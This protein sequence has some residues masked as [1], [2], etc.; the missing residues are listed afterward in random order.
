MSATRRALFAAAWTTL[1]LA[2]CAPPPTPG[3]LTSFAARYQLERARRSARLAAAEA[4]LIVRVEGRGTG[5]LPGL[6]VSARLAAP[7][8]CRLR[9]TWMLGTAFDLLAERDS[10]RAWLPT[11]HALIEIGGL[12]DSLRRPQ[13]VAL[14]LTAL[15][16]SW[17][18]PAAAWAAASAESAVVRLAWRDGADS[19]SLELDDATRPQRM[20]IQR[21]G[22]VV[23]VRYSG[24]RPVGGLQWP[25]RIEIADEAEWFRLRTELQSLRVLK[26]VN[27]RWF[28]LQPPAD[29][30]RLDWQ[31]VRAR[32]GARGEEQP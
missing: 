25:V 18:P 32:L 27:D 24:W 14:L 30:E 8:R 5:R 10:L 28:V 19:L 3:E 21:D 6:A 1:L 17:D 13:P 22:R 15:A 7:D 23:W 4:E 9:A 16:A 29:A 26:R 2:S 11:E 31:A 12:G 20:R